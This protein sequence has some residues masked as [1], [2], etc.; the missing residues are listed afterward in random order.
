M[1]KHNKALLYN[2]K[3]YKKRTLF[4]SVPQIIYFSFFVEKTSKLKR[5]NIF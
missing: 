1:A 2:F 4:Y 5:L 3:T